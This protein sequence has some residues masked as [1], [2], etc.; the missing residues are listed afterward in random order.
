MTFPDNGIIVDVV[1]GGKT[2]IVGAVIVDVDLSGKDDM[3]GGVGLD[4]VMLIL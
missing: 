2:P 1:G 3:G 4:G